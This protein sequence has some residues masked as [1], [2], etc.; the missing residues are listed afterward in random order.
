MEHLVPKVSSLRGNKG[1]TV[2]IAAV[3]S[4]PLGG[5]LSSV[6]SDTFAAGIVNATLNGGASASPAGSTAAPTDFTGLLQA[7][8]SGNQTATQTA[9]AKLQ[10]ASA[11][12]GS[13]G[14]SSATTASATGS[15]ASSGTG[16]RSFAT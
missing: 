10:A 16:A 3:S 9:L 15:A 11:K 4:S 12:A 1:E 8:V 6:V 5:A 14:T 13:S 2:S 7:L